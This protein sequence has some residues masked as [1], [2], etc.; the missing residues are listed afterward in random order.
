MS[1]KKL[2]FAVSIIST[3]L[4]SD[5]FADRSFRYNSDIPAGYFNKSLGKTVTKAIPITS[6]KYLR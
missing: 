2:L 6:T 4:S 1:F 3:C 5:A